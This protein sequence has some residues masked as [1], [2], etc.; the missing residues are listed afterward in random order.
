MN[1]QKNVVDLVRLP[2]KLA[3]KLTGPVTDFIGRHLGPEMDQI[4]KV[5]PG[6]GM[7]EE[8][9]QGFNGWVEG[10]PAPILRK[11]PADAVLETEPDE[12]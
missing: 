5:V 4:V 12:G 1:D 9:C 6:L 7:I 10:K 2:F 8:M 11:Q 3:H